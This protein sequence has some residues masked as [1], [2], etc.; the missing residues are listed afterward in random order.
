METHSIM[1]NTHIEGWHICTSLQGQESRIMLVRQ[2]SGAAAWDSQQ[3][4]AQTRCSVPEAPAAR[5]QTAFHV[6]A[7]T[8]WGYGVDRRGDIPL[9]RTWH[10]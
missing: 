1:G 6:A 7:V 2:A 5:F 8:V 10:V 9:H 4:A 3:M